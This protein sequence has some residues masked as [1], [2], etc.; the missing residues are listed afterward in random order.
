MDIHRISLNRY[1]SHHSLLTGDIRLTPFYDAEEC[2][3]KVKGYTE[4]LNKGKLEFDTHA[5]A[6][7]CNDFGVRV[8]QISDGLEDFELCTNI[9]C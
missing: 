3:A 8:H 2:I 4:E 9:V 5:V 1:L 7:T 6:S